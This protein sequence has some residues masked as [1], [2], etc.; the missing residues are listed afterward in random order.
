MRCEVCG[1][2][3]CLVLTVVSCALYGTL[4]LT[5]TLTLPLSY[6]LHPS[7]SLRAS[8]RTCTQQHYKV[9][10]CLLTR[11]V[12]YLVVLLLQKKCY[13]ILCYFL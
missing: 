4:T 3:A 10:T 6:A 8:G 2:R 7:R 12:H 9:D 13:F 1:P 5:L 11:M